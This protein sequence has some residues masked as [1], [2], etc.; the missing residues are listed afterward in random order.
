MQGCKCQL[1]FRLITFT[2]PSVYAGAIA[3]LAFI[4]HFFGLLF[5]V[6]SDLHTTASF[7]DNLRC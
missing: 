5:L 7:A 2:L 6:E 1:L 4:D 3:S